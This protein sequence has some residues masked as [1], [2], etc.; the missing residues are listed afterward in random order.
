MKMTLG[1]G[2]FLDVNT[3]RDIHA[4]MK[5]LVIFLEFT[6]VRVHNVLSM[7]SS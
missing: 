3:G 7:K 2:S 4:S 5:G 6:S 1:S